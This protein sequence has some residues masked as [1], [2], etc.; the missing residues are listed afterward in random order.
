MKNKVILLLIL[1]LLVCSCK[2]NDSLSRVKMQSGDHI[3]LQKEN[4]YGTWNLINI[5]IYDKDISI[6]SYS[7]EGTVTF[8]NNYMNICIEN[9]CNKLPY[10]VENNNI[11]I[12]NDG[13]FPSNDISVFLQE[14]NEPQLLL[15]YSINELKY[16]YVY[17]FKN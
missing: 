12:E 11:K 5:F 9:K 1:L 15:S 14:F 10:L 7:K 17:K 4:L 2:K 6:H 13:N 16:T 8:D 3:I